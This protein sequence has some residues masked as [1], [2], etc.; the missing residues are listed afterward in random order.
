MMIEEMRIT[1]RIEKSGDEEKKI[2]EEKEEEL[3][4]IKP[5]NEFDLKINFLKFDLFDEKNNLC[6]FYCKENLQEKTPKQIIS[7][8]KKDVELNKILILPLFSYLQKDNTYVDAFLRDPLLVVVKKKEMIN[9][10]KKLKNRL[11]ESLLEEINSTNTVFKNIPKSLKMPTSN[12]SS[13]YQFDRVTQN[14]IE[15]YFSEYDKSCFE[16]SPI[17]L[18]F[19]HLKYVIK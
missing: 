17:K 1:E 7:H 6:C 15:T 8:M 11:K 14:I 9:F 3:Q 12:L 2:E 19:L 13:V 5:K 10:S 16:T 18:N 4:L